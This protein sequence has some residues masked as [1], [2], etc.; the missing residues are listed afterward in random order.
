M[1]VN[2][3]FYGHQNCVLGDIASLIERYSPEIDVVKSEQPVDADVYHIMRPNHVEGD[4]PSPA[5]ASHHGQGIRN[6]CLMYGPETMSVFRDAEL[7]AVLNVSDV[8]ELG[9]AGIDCD[10]LRYIPHGVDLDD[11]QPKPDQS[12]AKLRILRVG[13]RYL[14]EGQTDSWYNAENK[15]AATLDGILRGL[16]GKPFEVVLL[17]D[18]HAGWNGTVEN[19]RVACAVIS[20]PYSKYPDVYQASDVY[21][22]TSRS[23][24]GPAS[25]LEA[26]ACGLPVV[27]TPT[28]MVKDIVVPEETG[29]FYPFNDPTAAVRALERVRTEPYWGSPKQKAASRAAAAPFS[30]S[31]VVARYRSAYYELVGGNL[32]H[33]TTVRQW[34]AGMLA[35]TRCLRIS[36]MRPPLY[37]R[38]CDD[39]QLYGKGF[40]REWEYPAVLAELWSNYPTTSLGNTL[41]VG[42]SNDL[43]ALALCKRYGSQM[44]CVDPEGFDSAWWFEAENGTITDV[45]PNIIDS[46]DWPD[47]PTYISSTL[48]SAELPDQAYDIIISTS[49]LEH[50]RNPV[51]A[52][53]TAARVLKPGGRLIMTMEYTPHFRQVIPQ[54]G[55]S[56]I[57]RHQLSEWVRASRLQFVGGQDWSTREGPGTMKRSL[58]PHLRARFVREPLP[59]F[60]PLITVLEK[61]K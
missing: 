1:R 36:E 43:L 32:V 29:L 16:D 55:L 34:H 48:Q 59:Y 33:A 7:V 25:L 49:V 3:V 50:D 9:Q 46:T 5:I 53:Q 27:S 15:G 41:I 22:V 24:G 17:T 11:F 38:L 54:L 61:P 39:Y 10:K 26:M 58:P 31:S 52:L 30:W 51:E 35:K 12:N 6:S 37:K 40:S 20:A 57:D 56:T 21:L 2:I 13:R 60:T 4:V 47:G 44:T 8:A 14:N 42:A 19:C 28:G 18:P 45:P 23:E